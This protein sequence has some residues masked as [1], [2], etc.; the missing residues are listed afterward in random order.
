MIAEILEDYA[1][2]HFS[3]VGHD[4]LAA[5]FDEDCVA[6]YLADQLYDRFATVYPE[7]QKLFREIAKKVAASY[8]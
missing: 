4:L 7:H 6:D 1:D 5:G 2:R 3:S 8:F